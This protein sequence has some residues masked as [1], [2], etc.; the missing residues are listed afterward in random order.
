M[1]IQL[2]DPSRAVITSVGGALNGGTADSTTPVIK[3]TADAGDIVDVYD[4]VRWLGS[5]VVAANGTW[6]FTPATPIK[7]GT[8]SFAAIAHD[9]DGNYGDSS[10]PM[11]VQINAGIVPPAA[12]SVDSVTDNVGPITGPVP[13]NGTTDDND[14]TI[15]GKGVAGDVVHVKDNGTEIGSA[16]VDANGN[17]SFKPV[18]PLA[19]GS[20]DITA[21]QTDPKTG[22]TSPASAD[23]PFKV[24]TTAPVAPVIVSVNDA[25]GPITGP[26]PKNGTTDDNDPTIKGTGT[27]GDVVHVMDNG[28]EIG[29]ATVDASGN[30]SL[31]PATPL[32]NGAHDVTATQANPATGKLSPVSADWPFTVAA[33]PAAPSVDSVTDAVGPITGPVPKNGTTDDNDPTIAGKGVA[34][35]VVHVKDNGTEIGSA[36]VD[37][38]GNWSFKPVTPLA[39]GSHDITATQTDPKTGATSPASADWPFKV[40]T[41]APVAPVVVSV[42]DAVGSITGPVPKNGVTDDND[43]TIK[44]TGVAGDVVHVMDNGKEIGTAKVDASGNWSFKPATALADGAHDITATQANPAT[45]KLSPVSNDWPF[46][47]DTYVPP[48]PSVTSVTD[49]VGPITGPVAKNGTTD[50]N[51]PTIAGRGISGS[52]VHVMDNGKEIGTATVDALGNWSLKPATP[53]ADGSHD[54]TAMQTDAVTGAT[55]PTSTDWPFKVDTTAPAPVIVS[56]NDAVGPI[57]GP[58]P[59]NGTTD[60]NDPTIKGTGVAGDVVH[61]KDNGT[62]IGTATV[63]ASGNWSFKP[64]TPL[65]DGAHDMTATQTNAAT[66]KVSPASADW[67]FNVVTTQPPAETVSITG[68]VD[69]ALGTHLALANGGT[70]F[71]ANPTVNGTVSTALQTGETLVVYRD[72]VKVGTA[73]VNGKSWSFQDSNV[74][75][76]N[77]TYTADVVSGTSHGTVSNSYAFTEISTVGQVMAFNNP[78]DNKAYYAINVGNAF[79]SGGVFGIAV[80]SGY[81]PYSFGPGFSSGG[82]GGWEVS[83]GIWIASVFGF[84]WEPSLASPVYVGL[85]TKFGYYLPGSTTYI[86]LDSG[87]LAKFAT[88]LGVWY[89]FDSG[90]LPTGVSAVHLDTTVATDDTATTHGLLGAAAAAD[91]AT[92]AQAQHTAVGDHQSFTGTSGHDTVDLNMDPAAY[93]KESTAHIQGSTAHPVEAAGAAPAVNTLHLTGDHQILDLTSLTGKTAAA[94]ISGIEVIDL[95]GHSNNLKLSLSDVLNLGEQDLFQKDGHQQMMVNGSNGDTVDL[96]NAHIAG[97][98]DGQW[99][100]AGTAQVGG[101]TYNVYEHSGAHTELLVQQGVQIALHN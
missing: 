40:D 56:V 41:T 11:S 86:P 30:W 84:P 76:G 25:V 58:V 77:H 9:S 82:G 2:K 80:D 50:D 31:K 49:A 52:T 32:A 99:Q 3:G 53:L 55:S 35:D 36:T 100:Q 87:N 79:S 15:A 54:I 63:D 75:V 97:V 85:T 28:K 21:T 33:A 4:G 65:A 8:H 24:D 47:V 61:I 73:T 18:T 22:A 94:K 27:A 38:N 13:K 51:D 44:G 23:W 19:D 66:G 26:V 7:A 57:T 12:P 88:H 45:G 78:A 93:F 62:E 20:H 59:K 37:A 92:D 46:T 90:T 67:P 95:G 69:N 17:W 98:A 48:A 14:P 6:S 101:V 70:T 74:P 42:N 68:M 91:P 83:P 1:A 60:D 16:T 81:G 89:N 5:A 72:G 71:D 34:G 10:V 64:A 96:S 39:D 29:T 43:P